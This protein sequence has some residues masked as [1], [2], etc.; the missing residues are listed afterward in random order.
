MD[1]AEDIM[2]TGL[3]EGFMDTGAAG[4]EYGCCQND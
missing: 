1:V 4:G 2:A 3:A